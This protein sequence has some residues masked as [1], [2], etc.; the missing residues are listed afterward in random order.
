MISVVS[1]NGQYRL[2]YGSDSIPFAVEFRAHRRLS[3]H[4]YPDGQV[5][6]LAPE[7]RNKEEIFQRVKKRVHWIA[8]GVNV[9]I[10]YHDI[11]SRGSY[12]W[13]RG[14]ITDTTGEKKP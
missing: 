1:K 5:E 13:A 3:I 10:L 7:G 14:E 11:Q 4:V 8:K 12:I 2:L 6:V 9:S